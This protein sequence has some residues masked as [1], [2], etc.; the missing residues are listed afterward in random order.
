MQKDYA[1]FHLAEAKEAIESVLA[2]MQADPDYDQ[3][4]F[5]ID[6]QH[7][8]WHINS[9]WNGRHFSSD[10]QALTDAVY[11]SFIQYPKDLEL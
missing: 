3:S 6:M 4:N 8:Y 7:V 11:Q 9:A 2:R 10:Q 1:L 5:A